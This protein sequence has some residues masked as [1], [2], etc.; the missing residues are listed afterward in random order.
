MYRNLKEAEMKCK[1][2]QDAFRYVV[3]LFSTLLPP[4]FL[5][6][7]GT[8]IECTAS[9]NFTN[10]ADRDLYLGLMNDKTKYFTDASPGVLP[11]WG[12]HSNVIGVYF[13]GRIRTPWLWISRPAV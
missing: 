4:S 9:G 7:G 6:L 13:Q 2:I 3:G 12:Q 5:M 1:F 11:A 8:F 10:P